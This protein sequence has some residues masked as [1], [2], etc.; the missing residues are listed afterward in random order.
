MNGAWLSHVSFAKRHEWVLRAAFVERR[1]TSVVSE[2]Q[3][4]RAA[5]R[6][7]PGFNHQSL[8]TGVLP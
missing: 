2:D 1:T 6:C 4:G 3:S 5:G 8:I 7:A